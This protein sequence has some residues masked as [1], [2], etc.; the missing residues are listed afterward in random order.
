MFQVQVQEI[1][2]KHL[3][4]INSKSGRVLLMIL[5]KLYKLQLDNIIRYARLR[6]CK[7]MSVICLR[8][9]EIEE[10]ILEQAERY[11]TGMILQTLPDTT[12][13]NYIPCL[14]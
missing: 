14:L 11:G 2:M 7:Y 6:D 10:D 8:D 12:K 1:E 13:I 3:Y 5:P 4:V 9:N